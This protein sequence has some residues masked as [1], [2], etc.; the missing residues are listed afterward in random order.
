MSRIGKMP[1]VIPNGVDVKVENSVLTVKGPKGTLSQQLSPEVNVII[2]LKEKCVNLTPTSQEKSANEKW[3]LFRALIDN[4]C[5]GVSKGFE[6]KLEIEGIGYK[7]E[8]RGKNLFISVG[9]SH[10]I[11]YVPI[12]GISFAIE[13]PTK[14][15]VTGID[16]QL[17]GQVAAEI[18]SI[19]KPEPYKGKGIKYAGEKIVR[20]AGKTGSK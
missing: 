3:G 12:D 17:V 15:S 5:T 9:F 11:L 2:D 8:L 13:G 16:K 20:K 7:A 4:M 10:P 6:K 18:R 14:I 1:V 19:R